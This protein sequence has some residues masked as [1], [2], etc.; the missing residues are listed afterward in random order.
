VDQRLA[1]FGGDEVGHFLNQRFASAGGDDVSTS[2][3]QTEREGAANTG[4]TSDDDGYT[5]GEISEVLQ[6]KF[7]VNT[8]LGLQRLIWAYMPP[9]TPEVCRQHLTFMKW[10]DERMGEAVARNMP[11]SLETLQHIY[12]AELVWLDR[13]FGNEEALITHYEAPGNIADLL[14]AFREIHAK[15]LGWLEAA[16]DLDVLIPHRN[17]QGEAFRMPVWQIVLHVVNHGSYHRGQVAAMLRAAG[18]APPDSDLIIWYR[19]QG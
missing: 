18:Y 12:L 10:A 11:A 13:I 1:A 3:C 5:A 4:G 19:Q 9:A 16:E 7:Q 2:L 14:A 8:R 15:W 17:L 6:H